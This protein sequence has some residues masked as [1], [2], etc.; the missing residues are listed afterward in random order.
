MED[1]YVD[2]DSSMYDIPQ[3]REIANAIVDSGYKPMLVGGIVRD[4]FLGRDSKDID[5]EVHGGCSYNEL[6]SI[7]RKVGNVDVVGKAFAVAKVTIDG[8]DFDVSLPRTDSKVGDGHK[9]FDVTTDSSMTLEQAASRR[10]FTINA[11]MIDLENDEVVDPYGGV[12]DIDDGV[13][14]VVNREKFGEDPLRAFRAARFSSTLNMEPDDELKNIVKSMDISQISGERIWG[15]MN[16]IFSS[17]NPSKGLMFMKETGMI[18]KLNMS[19]PPNMKDSQCSSPAVWYAATNVPKMKGINSDIIKEAKFLSTIS[20]MHKNNKSVYEIMDY[21]SNNRKFDPNK[22][23]ELSKLRGLGDI[24]YIPR[25]LELPVDGND[26]MKFGYSG[27]E[28]GE[29]KNELQRKLNRGQLSTRD[30]MLEYIKNK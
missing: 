8:E 22:A 25:V 18:D 21:C 20:D 15:E 27:R 30:E 24:P 6:T 23:S 14:R 10:D 5:I 1:E 13:L 11:I 19:L 16:K 29:L 2:H 12:Q 7:L 26:I 4:S 9:D 3:T 17:K 28:V